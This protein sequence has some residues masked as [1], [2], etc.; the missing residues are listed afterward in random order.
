MPGLLQIAQELTLSLAADV[1][2]LLVGERGIGKSALVRALCYEKSSE[3]ARLR[4]E[5]WGDEAPTD[6]INLRGSLHEAADFTGLP[7]LDDAADGKLTNFA[8]PTI[9]PQEKV[10]GERGLLFLDELFRAQF[11]VQQAVFQ[12][13]EH[14]RDTDG[15][16]YHRCGRYRL[17]AGWDVVAASNP[18]RSSAYSQNA[19]LD[20]AFLDRFCFLEVEVD[21]E[22]MIEWAAFMGRLPKLDGDEIGKILTYTSE[23]DLGS[24]FLGRPLQLD[25]KDEKAQ[26]V[27]KGVKVYPSPRSWEAVGRVNTASRRLGIYGEEAHRRVLGGLIGLP[28]VDDFLNTEPLISL[29]LIL[30]NDREYWKNDVLDLSRN[31]VRQLVWS[32]LGKIEEIKHPGR[33]HNVLDLLDLLLGPQADNANWDL[34]L[35]LARVIARVGARELDIC[36]GYSVA[37]LG[38]P[39]ALKQVLEVVAPEKN[40]PDAWL[41]LMAP[42]TDLCTAFG[43]LTRG[44]A[45]PV[46]SE[47]S[48][49]EVE[50]VLVD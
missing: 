10:H 11:D 48:H 16:V 6:Y 33:R 8:P 4:R 21:D 19:L 28:L 13:I 35:G 26:P 25:A 45:R 32:L 9:L 47:H 37:V 27:D 12:L 43:E 40:D 14:Q 42:R 34:V 24:M 46:E 31:G 5:L 15:A 20:S 23:R 50:G 22:Y 3:F 49:G 39:A 18:P 38:G 36:E 44:T 41:Q 29:A 17:P 2:P 7:Y 30:D 1:T